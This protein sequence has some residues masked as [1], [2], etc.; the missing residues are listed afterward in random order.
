MATVMAVERAGNV[1]WYY[2]AGVRL[3]RIG[4]D[5]LGEFRF[6]FD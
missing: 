5:Y 3:G 4:A 2:T 6:C 1:V